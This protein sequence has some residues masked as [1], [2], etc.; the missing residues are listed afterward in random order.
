MMD[1]LKILKL[2]TVNVKI[3]KNTKVLNI[4]QFKLFSKFL[5]NFSAIFY[6]IS[7]FL[8]LFL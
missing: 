8:S 6:Q 5:Q 4:P 7:S 2:T 3:N 1:L